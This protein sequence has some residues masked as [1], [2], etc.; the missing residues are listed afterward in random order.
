MFC[1]KGLRYQD[2]L[3]IDSLSID[4]PVTCIVGPSGSGKST[5][6][7]MLNRMLVPD[8]GEVYY[9][10]KSL[11]ETDAV[12]LR[13]EVCMLSQTP[14]IYPGDI[15]D[16]LQIGLSFSG[17]LAKSDKKL[18]EAME[19]IGLSKSLD[20]S[21]QT[22]SGGEK[23]RLCLCRVMLLEASCYLLDEPSA[24]LDKDTEHAVLKSFVDDCRAGQ[25]QIV[26]VTHSKEAA[27][28]FADEIVTLQNGGIGG[29]E[30]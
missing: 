25:R 24:A 30:A 26:M 17:R 8:A 27:A 20:D 21:P 10:G 28:S 16:N 1:V 9:N 22:L 15:R 13:R 11:A 7:K 2:I 4:K 18:R 6:L 19:K 12:E 3:S 5:L 29:G 14:V 23:Q